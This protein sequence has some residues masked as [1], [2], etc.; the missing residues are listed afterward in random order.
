MLVT[1]GS[2]RYLPIDI[3]IYVT[4]S[5]FGLY[6]SSP[7]VG[8]NN[9]LID[10]LPDE[11]F[12]EYPEDNVTIEE[13]LKAPFKSPFSR[14][15]II[16]EPISPYTVPTGE[17]ED[18]TGGIKLLAANGRRRMFKTYKDSCLDVSGKFL[19]LNPFPNNKF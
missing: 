10:V 13:K 8:R 6:F 16:R 19:S 14:C 1:N 12:I 2:R 11:G 9:S 18:T 4:N 3:L 5:Y 17:N 7:N 15:E